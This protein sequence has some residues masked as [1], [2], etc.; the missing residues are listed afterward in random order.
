MKNSTLIFFS[1]FSILISGCNQI[2]EQ[3]TNDAT[4]QY[5]TSI[6]KANEELFNKGNLD[7][8]DET[9]TNDYAEQGPELVK[10]YVRSLRTAFPDIEV[11]IEPIIGENNMVA[12]MR[13]NTGTHQ[14]E[15]MGFKPT[16]KKTSWKDMI[17]S[18]YG[19]EGKVVK[20]WSTSNLFEVLQNQKMEVKKDV[21]EEEK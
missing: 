5:K 2:E 1:I 7:Y 18:Q 8:A 3:K 17:F 9:F 15:Y 20:E 19:K 6:R 10:N 13:T 14:G 4:N 16:G 21:A 11:S 12:W